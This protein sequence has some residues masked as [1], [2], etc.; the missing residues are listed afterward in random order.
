MTG[1]QSA[2]PANMFKTMTGLVVAGG[3][4][5]GCASTDRMAV[6]SV[7]DDY[8]T[9]HPIIVSEEERTLDVPVASGARTLNAATRSNITAFARA[10]DGAGTGVLH[11]L[12]PVGAANEHAARRVQGDIL[13]AVERGG[14]SR[15]D[16]SIQHYDAAAHGSAA[17]VRLSYRGI[18]A[19]VPH[20]CGQWTGNLI[21]NTRNRHHRDYGCSMQ[22]NVAAQIEN[23]GDLLGPRALSQIDAAQRG[24]VIGTYQGGPQAKGSEV[25]Y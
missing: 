3:L 2:M 19:S 21:D 4:L 17:P 24:V 18:A 7:A 5:A 12:M 16:I 8:R 20:A 15:D 9:N 23:P 11:M 6:G 14:A 13:Y 22:N 1:V 25:E 10:F